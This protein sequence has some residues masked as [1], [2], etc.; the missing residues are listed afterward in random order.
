[1]T[2]ANKPPDVTPGAANYVL[3]V[4]APAHPLP[5]ETFATESA[6]AEHLR[7]LRE[8]LGARCDELVLM[9]PRMS[10]ESYARNH[11]Q[12]GTVSRR[13][14]GVALVPLHPLGTGGRQFWTRHAL[15]A[16]RDIWREASR[17][18]VVHSGV[19]HDLVRP[20]LLMGVLAAL[21]Q[22]KDSV[23]V[24]DIDN[25]HSARMSLDTARWS[26]K[27]YLLC[28]YLYDP[29]RAAQIR[30]A[31]SRC[32]VVLL[33]GRELVRD[34]GAGRRNVHHFYDT[35]HSA[36]QVIDE[37]GLRARIDRLKNPAHPLRAVYFGRF[38]PYKGV[39]RSIR[40]V[41][42]AARISGRPI[43]LHLVGSGDQEGELRRLVAALGA[44]P[45][46][47]FFA[48]VAYGAPLF[49]KLA[50]C[51][52]ALATPL[53]EDTPRAAFDA[54]A[55]GLPLVAFDTSYYRDLAASGAVAVAK[56]PE[57]E[58]LAERICELDRDRHELA[59]M[60]RKAVDFALENTQEVWLSRRIEWTFGAPH[61]T[62]GPSRG[63]KTGAR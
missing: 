39:D 60:A 62:D 29:L 25:R 11:R 51:D 33:K 58:D 27:S 24:V 12:L 34:Y 7:L 2:F 48:P 10:P 18:E 6:F 61:E 23:F 52:V 57:V 16:L 46:V 22:R 19:S 17:A 3:L 54:M 53:A 45:L 40:A 28:K 38:A 14:H 55:M 5:N 21:A 50:R 1:M 36:N 30:L 47:H 37:V 41:H 20:T 13:A 8:L 63:L 15:P 35:V 42:S 43:E 59:R 56:W 44:E 26:R 49:E 32:S 4:D 31:A 9:A